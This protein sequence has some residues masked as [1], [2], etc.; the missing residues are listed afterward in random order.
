MTAGPACRGLCRWVTIG[1]SVMHLGLAHKIS[2]FTREAAVPSRHSFV[3]C[4]S[5]RLS[6]RG[7]AAEGGQV[8]RRNCPEPRP[9]ETAAHRA[10]DDV[11]GPAFDLLQNPP[12]VFA[13]D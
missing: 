9:G 10:T 13:Q 7:S 4:R 8:R 3:G 11:E 1:C 12:D 2:G 6:G 5:R